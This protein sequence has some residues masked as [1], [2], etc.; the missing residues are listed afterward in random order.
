MALTFNL[1]DDSA[2]YNLHSKTS[3]GLRAG[4]VD[5]GSPVQDIVWGE[6]RSSQYDAISSYQFRN[7]EITAEIDIRA[8]SL[9]LWITAYRNVQK[10]LYE[11]MRYWESRG[12][13]GTR[14][15]LDISLNG[16]TNTT[17]YDV[18]SGNVAAGAMAY[19]QTMT[20]T[21][22]PIAIGVPITL[23][24]KP[25]G[26]SAT[27]S[28]VTS[29]S[30]TNNGSGSLTIAATVSGDY[31]SPARV[32]FTATAAPDDLQRLI[33][34]R[35][36]KGDV[37]VV[38]TMI[39]LGRNTTY[40]AVAPASNYGYAQTS[41]HTTANTS[42]A[43]TSVGV[44]RSQVALATN[45]TTIGQF[46]LNVALTAQTSAYTGTWRAY[47][48]GYNSVSPAPWAIRLSHN[49]V[50][51]TA[52]GILNQ[53]VTADGTSGLSN[54]D[55][56][57]LDLGRVTF[58]VPS[59]PST[60]ALNPQLLMNLYANWSATGGEYR[61]DALFLVPLDEDVLDIEFNTTMTAAV[62][63]DAIDVRPGLYTGTTAAQIGRDI[64]LN[65]FFKVRPNVANKFGYLLMDTSNRRMD[66]TDAGVITVEWYPQYAGWF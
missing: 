65:T 40:S 26:R 9:D 48:R 15:Y 8:T 27:L 39:P 61:F 30:I 14:C 63:D 45:T 55:W 60:A 4:R 3:Y 10:M 25:F 21:T 29:G 13:M 42:A 51:A 12:E 64:R 44:I 7:R 56:Q 37:S 24:C 49:N 1:T 54:A 22:A 58:P 43:G 35:R 66:I 17:R 36:T 23:T 11:S 32:T 20:V 57:L 52:D 38:Q 46:V 19:I 31:D 16:M 59:I 47:L 33:L 2:T 62:V 41:Y 18:L 6:A 34:W 28:T 50:N 5:I 53:S